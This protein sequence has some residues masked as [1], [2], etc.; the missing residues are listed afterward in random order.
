MKCKYCGTELPKGTKFCTNCGKDLSS[1]RKCVKC[2]EIIDDDATF[3]PYCGAE[4]PVY[5]EDS[6]YKKW[7]KIIVGIIVIAGVGAGTY[8]YH[9]NQ[10]EKQR[11]AAIADSIATQDSIKRVEQEQA[12]IAK[13]KADSVHRAD[14]IAAARKAAES[15][16]ILNGEFVKKDFTL[17]GDITQGDDVAHIVLHVTIFNDK[18]VKVVRELT[19]QDPK[20]REYNDHNLIYDDAYI[21]DEDTGQNTEIEWVTDDGDCM[22]SLIP[23]DASGTLWEYGCGMRQGGFY[24]TLTLQK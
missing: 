12:A 10:I 7:I 1:L 8:F 23:Q 20:L 16:V 15:A 17:A 21:T 9:E 3:C 2:G 5:L 14:S 13:A 4:Q 24:G 6:P 11:Q 19:W 18:H 22:N